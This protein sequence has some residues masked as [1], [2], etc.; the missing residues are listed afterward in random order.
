MITKLSAVEI[1]KKL[2]AKE[3]STKEVLTSYLAEIESKNGKLNALITV[4]AD[5]ALE[6]AASAQAM[7][8]KGEGGALTGVPY[9]LKDNISTQGIETTCASKILKGFVPPYNATSYQ[10]AKDNGMVLM[11]KANL[12]EFAMGA[13]NET[14][15]FGPVLNPWDTERSPGGSSGGSAAAVAGDLAPIA[16]GS[17]TGGSIR[18]PAAL[19]GLVGYKPTYGRVSRYGLVAFASSLDQIGPIGK[20]VE[21]VAEFASIITGNCRHDSTSLPESTLSVSELKSGSLQGK[22]IAIPKE[23]FGSAAQSGVL[24]ELYKSIELLRS[25]GVEFVEVS[26]PEIELG[27]TTYYIIAPCEASSNLARFDGVRYGPRIEGNGFAG[28]MAATRGELFGAEVKQRIMMGTYALSAGY[29]DAYYL[30]AQQIRAKMAAGFERV[31]ADFDAVISPTSPIVA[32]KIGELTEDPLAMKLVD[33]C[34]IPANMGG[35]PAISI[36][37]GLSDGLPVGLQ[38][39]GRVGGDESLLQI[40]YHSEQALGFSA[41]PSGLK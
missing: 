22:R 39:M 18:Q 1:G 30:R 6:Q 16:L 19:C 10:K 20:S 41:T 25:E 8:D 5:V 12:D 27:V 23:M 32:F 36:P 24:E 40:A 26:V 2:R 33:Y 3:F 4:C 15:A 11:G 35:F 38:L 37:C 9:V 31:F 29:Y 17:D 34:T 7:I 13:S 21:D 28:T 14:S